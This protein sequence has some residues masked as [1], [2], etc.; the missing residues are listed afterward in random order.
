M[1][2]PENPFI[3]ILNPS[4]LQNIKMAVLGLTLL[5]LR[6]LI[7][8]I[9]LILTTFIAYLGLWGMDNKAVDAKP[10]T[11][12]RLYLRYVVC[13]ILR[14]MFYCCGFFPTIKGKQASPRDAPILVVAPHSTFFDSLAVCVMG[15]PSV[16]AKAETSSIPFW[17]SLI[18][19]TQP[20]LVHRTDANSRQNTIN[21]I[22][23]RAESAEGESQPWQ[24]VFIFPEGTCTNRQ[25]LIT[26][27]LGSFYPGVP[28]QPVILRY[29]NMLDTVT[30]TWEGFTAWKVI[31][32]SLSQFYI[33][34]SM[35][36]LQPYIPSQEEKEDPKLFS[37]NVRKVMAEALNVPTTDSN[38]FD[39]LRIEKAGNVLKN[40]QKLQKKLDI[41]LTDAMNSLNPGAPLSVSE[42]ANA[43]AISEDNEELATVIKEL[44]QLDG[45]SLDA[46]NLRIATM[47]SSTDED[48]YESFISNSFS[49]YDPEQGDS[50][51]S[52]DSLRKL[53][54][55]FLFLGNKEIN[56]LV[57]EV[58]KED[59]ASKE[60]LHVYLTSR[61]PNYAK[62]IKKWQG[63]LLKGMPDLLLMSANLTKDLNKTM[64][65]VALS[66]SSFISAGKD[67]VQ[68]LSASVAASRDLMSE[69]I[70]SAVTSLHRRTGSRTEPVSEPPEVQPSEVQEP[71]KKTD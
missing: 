33:N 44:C 71:D 51:I 50:T 64:E 30:W 45:E 10:F 11:G 32:Y 1:S 68:D 4:P 46:R 38:Y 18:R 26:F 48:S 70:T 66:G 60:D 28:V 12:W 40:L 27:R 67:V 5:P 56:E 54:E 55:V 42:L 3:H 41:T 21:Q 59:T 7:A 43:L 57:L 20:V 25:A 35:E 34:I 39:Y 47:M 52:G 23:A 13:Y 22:S 53:C 19:F 14:F 49:L 37:A 29:E 2:N 16:V 58:L 69:T 9:C 24:Q 62:V 36:F 8:L 15:G 31:A 65:K 6:L 61:K 63:G 17:G